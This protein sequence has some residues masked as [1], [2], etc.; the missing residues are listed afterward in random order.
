MRIQLASAD[1]VPQENRTRDKIPP[2][3]YPEKWTD[4]YILSRLF[5]RLPLVILNI[6]RWRWCVDFR[7]KD[8][9]DKYA[10]TG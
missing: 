3:G 7:K 10:E 2:L 8:I 9:L 4:Y 5:F 6:L 1:R